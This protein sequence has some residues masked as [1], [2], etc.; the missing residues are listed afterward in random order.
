MCVL[1]HLLYNMLFCGCLLYVQSIFL[2]LNSTW[3]QSLCYVVGCCIY[4]QLNV[5]LNS[6]W[7][8]SLCC[9]VVG[10][11]LYI[12]SIEYGIEFHVCAVPV[13][14]CGWLLYIESILSGIEFHV[15]AVPVLCGWLVAVCTINCIWHWIPCGCSPCWQNYLFEGLIGTQTVRSVTRQWR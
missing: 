10:W 11:L 5:E 4:S 12:Q 14:L 15:G 8:Q 3:V 1:L 9:Y 6:M 2:E 7:L 13:L